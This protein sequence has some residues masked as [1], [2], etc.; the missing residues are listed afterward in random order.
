MRLFTQALT[1][2]LAQAS[3]SAFERRNR[4]VIVFDVTLHLYHSF[5]FRQAIFRVWSRQ[6]CG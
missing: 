5:H 4:M 3:I 2:G 6:N 1:L